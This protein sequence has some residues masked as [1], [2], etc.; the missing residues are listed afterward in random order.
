MARRRDAEETGIFQHRVCARAPGVVRRERAREA[1]YRTEPQPEHDC[2]IS[3]ETDNT[4]IVPCRERRLLAAKR[5]SALPARAS[6]TG[7]PEPVVVRLSA[8]IYGHSPARPCRRSSVAY[9]QTT[10]I[11]ASLVCVSSRRRVTDR[12][13]G[14]RRT[15]F[16]F[17][18]ES[19]DPT[20]S[21]PHPQ[22]AH[23]GHAFDGSSPPAEQAEWR[24]V[25]RRTQLDCTSCAT[26]R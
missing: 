23:D 19:K 20:P 25:A 6:Q 24:A 16:A 17:G 18:A 11:R 2:T 26:A 10:A 14:S 15:D 12:D 8:A 5:T 13:L 9:A 22:I 4:H 21:L 7:R 3:H 1:R